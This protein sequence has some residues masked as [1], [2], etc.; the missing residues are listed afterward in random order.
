MTKEQALKILK[1]ESGVKWDPDVVNAL[2]EVVK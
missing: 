1:E 2:F